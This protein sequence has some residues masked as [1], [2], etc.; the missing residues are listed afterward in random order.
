MK[1]ERLVSSDPG[2]LY[3][4][5]TRRKSVKSSPDETNDS[6]LFNSEDIE[7]SKIGSKSKMFVG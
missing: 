3:F 5:E 2:E 6:M 4:L 7:L 1:N